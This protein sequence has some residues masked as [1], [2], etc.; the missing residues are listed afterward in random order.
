MSV[1]LHS[2]C[3]SPAVLRVEW[4]RLLPVIWGTLPTG[5]EWGVF[6]PT[7]LVL[8]SSWHALFMEVVPTMQMHHNDS[9]HYP[10]AEVEQ[11]TTWS[12]PLAFDFSGPRCRRPQGQGVLLPGFQYVTYF[13]LSLPPAHVST[14][15]LQRLRTLPWGVPSTILAHLL[16]NYRYS[17]F[18]LFFHSKN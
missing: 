14:I 9:R 2:H 7:R 18:H 6:D 10:E 13:S 17:L 5:W 12:T 1:G 8:E 4:E 15:P 16:P 11:E 3:G